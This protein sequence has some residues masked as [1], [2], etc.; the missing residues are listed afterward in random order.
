[1]FR[2]ADLYSTN[3]PSF[4]S[5]IKNFH[6]LMKKFILFFLIIASISIPLI[7]SNSILVTRAE[8]TVNLANVSPVSTTLSVSVIIGNSI[9]VLL[10][11]V[12]SIALIMFIYGG[13]YMLTSHGNPEMVKKGKEVL[14]WA[15]IGLIV[16][17]G[18]YIFVNFILTG[19]VGK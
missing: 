11:I 3:H 9:K 7:F 13:M 14:I 18:S 4:P 16:I 19:I 15:I 2:N 17:F 10:G 1:M 5:T 6:K 12:G 8:Q